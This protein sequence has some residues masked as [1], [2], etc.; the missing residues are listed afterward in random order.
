M[1][2]DID[3]ES[4]EKLLAA[5]RGMGRVVVTKNDRSV[6]IMEAIAHD[7]TLMRALELRH[8]ELMRAAD[9]CPRCGEPFASGDAYYQV[10]LP[11]GS[12]A[13]VHGRCMR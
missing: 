9:A 2:T 6:E 1:L 12:T 5:M 13:S 8:A 3:Q 4:V 7:R 10:R 11:D